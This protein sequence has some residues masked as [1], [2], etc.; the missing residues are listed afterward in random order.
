MTHPYLLF[1]PYLRMSGSVTFAGWELGPLDSFQDRWA[2]P[3]FEDQANAFLS[4]FVG[5][6]NEPIEKPA[7]LCR[8]GRPLDG[9]APSPEEVGALQ[10]ALIFAFVDG[11][12]RSRPENHDRGWAMVTADNAELHVWPIDLEEGRV[13][14]STGYLVA[15]HTVGFGTSDRELVLSPPVD[16]HMPSFVVHSPDALVLTGIYE[17]VLGSL[18]SPG[19]SP[20]SDAL[21]VA[22]DWFAKAWHN[23]ATVEY[24]ER[25]VYL[26]IAFEA[27]TG[28]SRN[29]QSARGLR[30]MFEALP[31][32]S[33]EDSDILVWSPEEEPVHVR[34]WKDKRGRV[35]STLV[36]DLEDWFMEFGGARNSIIHKGR[37]PDLTYTGANSAYRGPFFFTAEFL[38]R[39]VIKVQLTKLGYDDAWHPESWRILRDV[40]EEQVDR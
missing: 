16:L 21:R 15:T 31:G 1:C 35:Q 10:L 33:A 37:T 13:V 5:T 20:D 7:L 2:D 22:V 38:L 3:R 9:E 26:K 24:P 36:T 28:T 17:T 30:K 4:K 25:L 32:T 39:V 34:P 23:T 29:W 6:D 19:A 18:R 12:P 11:N 27:L 40:L 14:K 8:A